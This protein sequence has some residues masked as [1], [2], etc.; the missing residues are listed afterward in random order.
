M[1]LNEIKENKGINITGLLKNISCRYEIPESTLR[2]N[3]KILRELGLI[4]SGTMGNKGIS[5]ELT[6]EAENII[7]I[8]EGDANGW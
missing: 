7:K 5:V 1:V 4:R 2:Y 8:M 6:R 3:A